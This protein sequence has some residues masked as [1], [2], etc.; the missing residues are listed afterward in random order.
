MSPIRDE[1]IS[2]DG[3]VRLILGDTLEVLPTLDAGSVDAVVT[4]SPY[5]DM[6]GGTTINYPGVAERV[7]ATQTVGGELGNSAGLIECRRIARLGAV[8]FCSYHWIEKCIELLG[9]KR[10][11]LISWYKRNSPPS[12]NNSPYFLTEYAWAVQYGVGIGWRRL[13]THI[14]IPMLQ[15]GCMADERIT[16]GGKAVHPTQ[17][18]VAL[19]EAVL[20]PGMNSVCD[21]YMGLGSCGVA[22]IRT[23]RTFLGIDWNREY[24]EIA[25]QRCKD[26]LTR[27]PLFEPPKPKQLALLDT[28]A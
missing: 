27:F 12:V 8:A 11:A 15:G 2:D 7:E 28:N 21:P 10:R 9:G 22:C 1:W 25:V 24:W 20:L 4:D 18:P 5:E 19:F 17:K 23:R 16:N 3:S 13:R 6:K 14:D 26:E